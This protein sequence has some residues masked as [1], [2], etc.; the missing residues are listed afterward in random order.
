MY[1]LNK[2]SEL[3]MSEILH[4]IYF[5]SEFRQLMG[6]T[7]LL[8]LHGLVLQWVHT[9]TTCLSESRYFRWRVV[10]MRRNF[11]PKISIPKRWEH[12]YLTRENNKTCFP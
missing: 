10:E 11:H 6:E 5:K 3:Y 7:S 9:S 1:Y 4:C 2:Y 8:L 12:E